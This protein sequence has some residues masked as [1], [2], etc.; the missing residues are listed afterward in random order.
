MLVGQVDD[1][2]LLDHR[3]EEVVRRG[4]RQLA[5][6][7]DP[8][9][10]HRV[11]LAGQEAQHAQRPGRR[12]HLTHA[13][14][15]PRVPR[16]DPGPVRS[17]GRRGSALRWA[18]VVSV[19]SVRGGPPC[20]RRGAR[21]RRWCRWSP[22]DGARRLRRVGGPVDAGVPSCRWSS[23]V[24][25][26]VPVVL[27]RPGGAASRMR[28]VVPDARLVVLRPGVDLGVDAR[29]PRG[30][31][32]RSWPAR[33]GGP[34]RPVRPARG[35]APPRPAA[36]SALARASSA[37]ALRLGESARPSARP[38][39]AAPRR[40]LGAARCVACSSSTRRA[41][42]DQDHHDHDDP[43][44]PGGMGCSLHRPDD[45]GSSRP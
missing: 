3:A 31:C 41:D 11:G 29:R 25:P 33:P 27:G 44:E 22:P 45:P 5:G 21:R 39:R 15:V 2:A 40:G 19:A 30:A 6:A 13:G 36:S 12:R 32:P 8:V 28:L 37:V 20:L 43:D 38:R 26:V 17:L 14:I 7:G 10:R 34:A 1:E 35:R 23:P 4:A 42:H 16:A 9:E 18:P 24:V